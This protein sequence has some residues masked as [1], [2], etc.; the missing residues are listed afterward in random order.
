MRDGVNFHSFTD[1]G[2]K[3]VLIEKRP[4]SVILFSCERGGVY[5]PT[6]GKRH[7]RANDL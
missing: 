2:S 7:R 6:V 1:G 4:L 5:L 3:I